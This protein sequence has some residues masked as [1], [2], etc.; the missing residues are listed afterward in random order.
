MNILTV[1]SGNSFIKCILWD[2]HRKK[3]ESLR[4]SRADNDF[5]LLLEAASR[6]TINAVVISSVVLPELDAPLLEN[7]KK[8][9]KDSNQ[10]FHLSD[11]KS[12]PIAISYENPKGLG[13]DRIAA[14]CGA[15]ELYGDKATGMLVID[16]GTA[17]TYDYVDS[18]GNF[19]GGN[20]APGISIRLSSLHDYAPA[21]PVVD[22]EGACPILGTSTE[23]AIRSG[24]IRGVAGEI[25]YYAHLLPEDTFL[26]LTGGDAPVIT[27][28]I[29][30]HGLK[31]DV[32]PDLV[33]RGLLAILEN[34]QN[35]SEPQV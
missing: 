10:I 12:Y 31:F 4:L 8:I 7:L 15:Y 6:Y 21:L 9:T 29:D 5:S 25:L 27:P 17:I 14:A 35:S 20:I 22:K 33:H 18:D 30:C 11:F 23:C 1:D 13:Q 34:S 28:F 16:L 26:A 19:R 2:K 3:I 24:V 32:N